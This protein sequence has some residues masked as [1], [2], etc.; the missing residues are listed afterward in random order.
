MEEKILERILE[1]NEKKFRQ[2]MASLAAP[3]PDTKT[4]FFS[5]RYRTFQTFQEFVS[6]FLYH[7]VH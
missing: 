1:D 2:V 7:T 3:K 6:I 4:G 5:S